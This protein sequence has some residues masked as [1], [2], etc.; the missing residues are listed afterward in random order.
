MVGATVGEVATTT[1]VVDDDDEGRSVKTQT[2]ISYTD[3]MNVLREMDVTEVVVNISIL[4][5][6]CS[7]RISVERTK[8]L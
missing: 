5:R 7:S 3:W 4:V 8:F 2:S 6:T 1:A